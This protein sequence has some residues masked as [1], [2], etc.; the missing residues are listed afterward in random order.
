M[1]QASLFVS[2]SFIRVIGPTACI[3]GI[4]ESN[5]KVVMTQIRQ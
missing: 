2:S 5:Y 3:C 1:N 4:A